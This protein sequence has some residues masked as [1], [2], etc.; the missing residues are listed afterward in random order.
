VNK[1]AAAGGA[2]VSLRI[3]NLGALDFGRRLTAD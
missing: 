3:E 1:G 2:L